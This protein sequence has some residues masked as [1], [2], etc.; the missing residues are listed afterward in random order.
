MENST[1]NSEN[2]EKI[3]S[4]E[5]VS[6][7]LSTKSNDEIKA[8]FNKKGLDIT[9]EQ[10]EKFKDI[11][12]EELL[13]EI[14]DEELKDASGGKLNKEIV[15]DSAVQGSG[16]G[17]AGGGLLGAGLGFL[18]SFAHDIY[19]GK[20]NKVRRAFV[21]AAKM[22]G[23]GAASGAFIGGIAGTGIGMADNSENK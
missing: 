5:F 11:V 23:I 20:K 14:S 2:I 10:L 15:F 4:D 17:I 7:V 13:K 3:F 22:S 1:N 18:G 8:M 6:H 19:Q 16:F 9:D 21:N 12:N